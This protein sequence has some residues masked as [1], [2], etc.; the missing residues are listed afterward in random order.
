MK[1]IRSRFMAL[2]MAV[3]MTATVAGV[4]PTYEVSAKTTVKSIVLNRKN[5]TVYVGQKKTIKLFHVNGKAPTKA[6]SAVTFKIANKKVATV[7]KKGVVTGVSRGKTTVTVTS[8]YNKK[9]TA[10][11]TVKVKQQITDI[12]VDNAVNN[13]VVVRKGKKLKLKITALP[14][15]ANKKKVK[16]LSKNK[17]VAT[18]NK[19]TGVVKAKKYG[20]AKIVIRA[21]YAPKDK[22]FR[23]VIKV[24]VPKKVVKSVTAT[25][26]NNFITV[27][28]TAKVTAT[29]APSDATCKLVSYTSSDESVATVSADGVVTALKP[30]K[31]TITVSSLDGGIKS[32]IV[33]T[34][35]SRVA[36]TT[37]TDKAYVHD[38]DK[39]AMSYDIGYEGVVYNIAR[40]KFESDVMALAKMFA[41]ESF[42]PKKFVAE[43]SND[44]LAD[45]FNIFRENKTLLTKVMNIT[46]TD[47]EK[48]LTIDGKTYSLTATEDSLLLDHGNTVHYQNIKT[49][50]QGSDYVIT[51]DV[52]E[53]KPGY[54]NPYKVV[55]S[56][57]YK[58][59]EVSKGNLVFISIKITDDG[60]KAVYDRNE[61][62]V[63]KDKYP[64]TPL[65]INFV[66]RMTIT[67]VYE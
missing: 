5:A 67:N 29:V 24:I 36:G 2:G 37:L 52:A 28:K 46:G 42:N 14:K 27:G 65:F 47:A 8:K 62:K 50:K 55:I 7:S 66:E 30:G 6:N 16:F 34:V 58:S 39:N 13:T 49:T 57:D 11:V 48:L 9:A 23:K 15:N 53:S 32:S 60:I 26:D 33:I 22:K 61:I 12:V 18:V 59:L 21:V 19:K 3:A 63:L 54:T 41:T 44:K 40:E 51:F 64:Y 10:K 45:T 35:P 31:T 56:D 20:T 38:L 4:L 43:L 25:V 17:K 1:S